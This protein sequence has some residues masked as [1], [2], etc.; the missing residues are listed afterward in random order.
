MELCAKKTTTQKRPTMNADSAET[1]A[2]T[3]GGEVSDDTPGGS[4]GVQMSE[5]MLPRQLNSLDVSV[6]VCLG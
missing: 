1:R 2:T 6:K 4:S 3:V 5:A